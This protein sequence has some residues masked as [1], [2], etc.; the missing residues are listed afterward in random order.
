M[1][2]DSLDMMLETEQT[3]LP[4]HHVEG[5]SR[6]LNQPEFAA[7][8]R[9]R[10]LV[11]MVEERVLPERI[12]AT[13]RESG[14]KV[15][16]GAENREEL[17]RPFGVIVCRYGRTGGV[18]G[19]ICVVGLMRMSYATAIAGAR[20]LAAAMSRMVQTLDSGDLPPR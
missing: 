8:E 4:E 11:Q 18:S 12:V 15:Y 19:A 9:T 10:L 14:P 1:R 7:G 6:L 3:D 20:H 13:A 2:R 5:L 17:L 16:I